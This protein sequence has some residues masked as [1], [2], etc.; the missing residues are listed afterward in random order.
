[1]HV[2]PGQNIALKIPAHL[3][4]DTVAFYR[5][6]LRL[7]VLK[8]SA[9][10]VV[11]EFGSMRLWLDRVEHQSQTDVW[12]ELTTDDLDQ[13][14]KLVSDA[15]APVRDQLEPL[16]SLRGHWIS[17]PAGVVLLLNE[18]TVADS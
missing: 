8:E 13:A 6:V 7:P 5:D 16:G 10:A 2:K 4:A 9:E 18:S 3:H 17:D 14:T 15:G 12:L 11:F 1:M